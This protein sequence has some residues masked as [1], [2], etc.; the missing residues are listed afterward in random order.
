MGFR[1]S[2]ESHGSPRRESAGIGESGRGY[3]WG[4]FIGD[5]FDEVKIR[6][7]ESDHI[8]TRHLSRLSP[9]LSE[10][11]GKEIEMQLFVNII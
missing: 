6:D 7:L 1:G 11:Q 4:W 5:F 10:F 3:C 9:I 8:Y 2:R